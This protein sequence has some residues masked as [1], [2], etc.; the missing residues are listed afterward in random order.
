LDEVPQ[1][2]RIS[3]NANR[4]VLTVVFINSPLRFNL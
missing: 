2:V 4:S 1:A 3:K